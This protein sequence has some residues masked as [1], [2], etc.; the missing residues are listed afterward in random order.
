MGEL[1]IAHR[2]NGRRKERGWRRNGGLQHIGYKL[3]K[4]P[5]KPQLC[6][7]MPLFI[8]HTSTLK[9]QETERLPVNS[10]L[11]LESN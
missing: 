5:L 10:L 11:K 2:Q 7:S 6:I 1:D 8:T 4:F 9:A 3:K